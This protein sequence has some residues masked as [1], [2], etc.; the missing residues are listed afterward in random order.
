MRL[1]WVIIL[2]RAKDLVTVDLLAALVDD[3]VADLADQ[4]QEACGRV[5][6]LGVG[7]DEEDGVH[8]GHEELGDIGQVLRGVLKLVEVLLEGLEEL[9]VLVSLDAS[10]VNLLLQLA[11]GTSLGR[12]VL[13]EELEHLLD[14]LA[15][16]LLADGVQ[17]LA[18]VLPELNLSDGAGVDCLF[19]GLLRVLAKLS[20]DLSCPVADGVLEDGGLVFGGG[21]LRLGDISGRQRQVCLAVDETHSDLSVGQELMELLHQVLADQVGPANL[22]ERVAKNGQENFLNTDIFVRSISHLNRP[23]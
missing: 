6:V 2:D 5:V 21:L 10:N 17:V 3:G 4:H 18:L 15:R 12:L 22:I 8:D 16:E 13:L 11:E 20:L 9:V 7:P 1:K 19:K 14:A 23:I